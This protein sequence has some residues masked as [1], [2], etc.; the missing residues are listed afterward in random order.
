[1]QLR[2]VT[3]R[4]VT[5]TLCCFMLC[6]NMWSHETEDMKGEREG[7]RKIKRCGDRERCL[8]GIIMQSEEAQTQAADN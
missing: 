3:L 6:S 8:A 5:L 2:F 1:M 7:E 4:H